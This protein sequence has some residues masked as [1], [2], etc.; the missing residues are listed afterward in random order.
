MEGIIGEIRTWAGNFAPR[1]WMFCEGQTLAIANN[2]VLFAVIGTTYGGDGVTT[3]KLPDLRGRVAM[4]VG[5]GTGLTKRQAGELTGQH[6][7]TLTQDEIPAHTHGLPAVST[8]AG[9]GSPATAS[10]AASSTIKPYAA[11]ADAS[12]AAASISETGS[13]QAHENMQPYLAVRYVIC[14]QGLFPARQ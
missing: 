2:E 4:G 14:Y 5:T 1:C 11:S 10:P 3:F 9:V 6:T 12:M 13:G 8:A 7:V